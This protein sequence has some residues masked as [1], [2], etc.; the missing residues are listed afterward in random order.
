MNERGRTPLRTVYTAPWSYIVI[1]MLLLIPLIREASHVSKRVPVLATGQHRRWRPA[2]GDLIVTT[3]E[4]EHPSIATRT[5]LSSYQ[6][7]TTTAIPTNTAEPR[8]HS[9]A[10]DMRS[11]ARKHVARMLRPWAPPAELDPWFERTAFDRVRG[12]PHPL[13][14]MLNERLCVVVILNNTVFGNC[15]TVC[16][17]PRYHFT[18]GYVMMIQEA[19]AEL[20]LTVRPQKWTMPCVDRDWVSFKR[21]LRVVRGVF[22]LSP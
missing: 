22:S 12:P 2:S 1:F 21:G 11:W 17:N 3:G 5:H 19:I 16:P 8:K 6:H 14:H 10:V 4:M 15:E 9:G 18:K 20:N 13:R 7:A